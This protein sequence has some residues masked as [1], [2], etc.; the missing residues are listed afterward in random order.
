M[1]DLELNNEV[2]ALVA[3]GLGEL[4]RDAIELVVLASLDAL[5]GLS[6]VVVLGRRHHPLTLIGALERRLHPALV[7]ASCKA[8][9]ELKSVKKKCTESYLAIGKQS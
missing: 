2:L 4:G 8:S 9:G 7:P 6:V 3:E 1:L 5:G